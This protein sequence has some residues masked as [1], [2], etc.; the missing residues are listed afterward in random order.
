MR[1]MRSAGLSPHAP[2]VIIAWCSSAPS[3]TVSSLGLHFSWPRCKSHKQIC[4]GPKQTGSSTK[5]A[6]A[7]NLSLSL[8]GTG[9]VAWDVEGKGRKGWAEGTRP[10][11]LSAEKAGDT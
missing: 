3:F 6:V 11:P 5:G 4:C 2:T 8:P 9:S 7:G 10:G 1:W